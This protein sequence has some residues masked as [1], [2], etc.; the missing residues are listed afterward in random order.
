MV[1]I[2]FCTLQTIS[3]LPTSWGYSI[4]RYLGMILMRVFKSRR[5]F[6]ET[7][8]RLCFPNLS[9]QQ[10]G[11]LVR[12]NFQE[13]GVGIVESSWAWFRP[14]SFI[15][16]HLS[17]HGAE[18]IT[19]AKKR[20]CGVL[21]IGPHNTMSDLVAMMVYQAVGRIVITY[22][23]QDNQKLDQLINDRRRKFGDLTDV[24]NLRQIRKHLADRRIVWFSPDQDLGHRGSVFAPFFGNEACTITTPAR[25]SEPATVCPI[26]VH[27]YRTSFHY[28]LRFMEF[29]A[30]YP[31]KNQE[32]NARALNQLIENAVE[33]SPT[34]YMWIHRRFKTRPP[35]DPAALYG[36][37]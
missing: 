31:T 19:H 23:P 18:L 28:H 29:P 6:C 16:P 2:L 37:H 25:L 5:R 21:L 3:K 22:R 4:G 11:N 1:S 15:T 35:T 14:Q 8:V 34:Q 30:A 36:D 9:E 13:L 26:F 33:M 32:D 20:G 12:A 7:N 24:R 17:I 27:A 10:S